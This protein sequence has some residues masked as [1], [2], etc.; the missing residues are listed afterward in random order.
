MRMTPLRWCGLVVLVVAVGV[1]GW[2]IATPAAASVRL[3][4][5][6]GPFNVG[7]MLFDLRAAP[8][9]PAAQRPLR[10][11]LWYPAAATSASRQPFTLQTGTTTVVTAG[12]SAAQMSPASGPYPVLV[13]VP[14]WD[15]GR[16][17]CMSQM[18]ELASQGF[19]V[20]AIDDLYPSIGGFN[21]SSEA[22]YQ[23]TLQENAEKAGLMASQVETVVA[24]VTSLNAADP[25]GRF[26]GHLALDRLGI[27]G[28]SFGG[29]VAFETASRDPKFKAV[30]N[31]DGWLFGEPLRTWVP[32]PSMV[33]T[34]MGPGGF[35]PGPYATDSPDP[36]TRYSAMLDKLVDDQT[37]K[38]LAA[39]G[40]YF[41]KISG[42][43]HEGFTD[44]P[45][46]A[47][48]PNPP[49]DPVR[50]D[51]IVR[52]YL[53]AF[54]QKYLMDRPAPLLDQNTPPDTAAHLK[55]WPGPL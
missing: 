22:A 12:I 52:A 28:F 10:I 27:Y 25:A 35:T 30:A 54:F 45:M 31:M 19:V 33:M 43:Q 40:G 4:P 11:R 55:T 51:H 18:Q 15:G 20:A 2:V 6:T 32:Q 21:F 47:S 41:L 1:A 37:A 16:D 7:T 34:E 44:G 9:T 3:P 46:V 14:G 26:N 53:V 42:V 49:I 13:F 50:V 48:T 36:T 5:P 29:A 23:R 24:F 38:G 39:H 17:S 8:T